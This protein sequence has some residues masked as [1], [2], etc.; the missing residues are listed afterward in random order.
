MR[1]TLY[2]SDVVESSK[3]KDLLDIS[4]LD[5]RTNVITFFPLC[6]E[7]VFVDR[8]TQEAI[9]LKSKNNDF[10]FLNLF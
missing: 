3:E 2:E 6:D 10:E 7:C 5:F 9:I 1:L 4:I 8:R